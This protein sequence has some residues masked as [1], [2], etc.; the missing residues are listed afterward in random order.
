VKPVPPQLFEGAEFPTKDG[1]AVWRAV[2]VS[3]PCCCAIVHAVRR[4][5]G[6]SMFQGARTVGEIEDACAVPWTVDAACAGARTGG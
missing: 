1:V 5:T 4:D 2:F 3:P 6:A